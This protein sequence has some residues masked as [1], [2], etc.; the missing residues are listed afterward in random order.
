VLPI[1]NILFV[2]ETPSRADP[3]DGPSLHCDSLG[4]NDAPSITRYS[5]NES[6]ERSLDDKTC[7]RHS[8][9]MLAVAWASNI[10]MSRTWFGKDKV[11]RFRVYPV[12][13]IVESPSLLPG[14][15]FVR[16]DIKDLLWTF[17]HWICSVLLLRPTYSLQSNPYELNV[18]GPQVSRNLMYR[19][20]LH[21]LLDVQDALGLGCYSVRVLGVVHSNRRFSLVV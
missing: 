17:C 7:P 5:V 3:T 20:W 2:F 1:V 13:F 6:M 18:D 9:G 15:G 16:G 19:L 14:D 11:C 21:Y 8:C 4:L 12:G 10:N